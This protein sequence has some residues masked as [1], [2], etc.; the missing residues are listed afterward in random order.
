MKVMVDRDLN[1]IGSGG[2]IIAQLMFDTE[3]ENFYIVWN[4][5]ADVSYEEEWE[6]LRILH[7]WNCTKRGG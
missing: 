3:K 2:H 4:M 7:E 5:E 1:L 6:S